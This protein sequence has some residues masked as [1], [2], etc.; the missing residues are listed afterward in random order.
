M[1]GKK[2]EGGYLLIGVMLYMIF[3]GLTMSGYA[4]VWSTTARIENEE[5]LKFCLKEMRRGI[6]K[7]KIK[8]G[9]NPGTLQELVNGKYI[10]K[11]YIDPF[12]KEKNWKII[13]EGGR[14]T[15][16]KSSSNLKNPGGEIYSKW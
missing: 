11:I 6:E 5:Q 7:Y 2:H 15:D 16:V 4:S 8:N 12:T 13:E 9:N 3:L 14:I 10:R 1:S